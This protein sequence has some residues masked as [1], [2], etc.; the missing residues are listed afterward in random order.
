MSASPSCESKPHSKKACRQRKKVTQLTWLNDV[1]P[2]L[3]LLMGLVP[4]SEDPFVMPGSSL[5]GKI[6]ECET[7]PEVRAMA[8]RSTVPCGV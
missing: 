8:V 5:V 6:G 4:S 1:L 2:L 3:L 7:A